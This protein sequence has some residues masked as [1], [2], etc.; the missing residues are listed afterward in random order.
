MCKKRK[1]SKVIGLHY[2]KL[3]YRSIIFIIMAVLYIQYK[4]FNVDEINYTTH[5]PVILWTLWIVFMIE[6]LLRLFPS[7]FES[8]GCQKQF[9]QNYKKSGKTDIKIS[10][11]NAVVLVGI[12][13]ISV[14]AIFG[15][16]HMN[17]I[18]DDAFMYMLSCIYS[19]CDIICILFFCP[20]QTFFLKNKCC[21]TCR[22]YNW[23]YAMMF[24]PLLFVHNWVAISLLIMSVIVLLRWEF[25]VFKYPERFSDHTNE[26]LNCSNCSER[27]C[28]HK[29][30]LK[31]LWKH[32]DDFKNDR[33]KKLTKKGE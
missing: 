4:F 12:I 13:W 31:S 32:L 22:I 7:K 33:I 1:I 17:N 8:P 20:F 3:V 10:D 16:L 6:M 14:N 2:I 25:T 28:Q 18:I 21:C 15:L 5:I 9:R 27:L 11:N 26:Y 23:D 29:T 19:V 30:Q 24:T